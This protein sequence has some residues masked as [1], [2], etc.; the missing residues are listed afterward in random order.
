MTFFPWQDYSMVE[1][2]RGG[3]RGTKWAAPSA[4]M[5]VTR[6]QG[7]SWFLIGRMLFGLFMLP[8]ERTIIFTAHLFSTAKEIFRET[9]NIINANSELKARVKSVTTGAGMEGIELKDGSRIRFLARS[10]GSARGWQADLVICDEAYD[11]T[12]DEV[13]SLRPTLTQS[14]NP[15]FI[16]ASS[17]GMEASDV[18][19]DVRNKGIAGAPRL[20]YLEWSAP[21][22]AENDSVEAIRQANPSLG[23]SNQTLESVLDDLDNMEEERYRRERL[24]IWADLGGGNAIPATAWAECYDPEWPSSMELERIALGVDV[25]PDR[26]SGTI[27]V[28]GFR[29][30]T[31]ELVVELFRQEEGIDWIAPALA[32]LFEARGR[33]PVL[34][35]GMSAASALET[36]MKKVRVRPKYLNG[37]VYAQACGQFYDA[38][39]NNRLAHRGQRDLNRAVAVAEQASKGSSLW[40]WKRPDTTHNIS[41]LCAAT[42]ATRGALQQRDKTKKARPRR[43]M[44]L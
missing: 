37:K 35:D 29:K 26:S 6:Q 19:R 20:A 39:V 24:G 34:I 5:V 8:W 38:V 23:Y 43:G 33:I 30:D 21:D 1:M 16:Y 32:E 22:D 3:T 4:A 15:Q 9:Q 40:V 7:K 2:L 17:A 14:K 44:V 25:P 13:A 36:D 31:G 11:L 10:R 18:L 28:S 27:A 12:V 41:P 42:L